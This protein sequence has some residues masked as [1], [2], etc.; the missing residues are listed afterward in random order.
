MPPPS[1]STAV[2]D[3]VAIADASPVTAPPAESVALIRL[4]VNV[5]GLALSTLAVIAVVV[6][7]ELAQAFFVSLLLGILAAYTLNP[8]IAY[9]ERL[10]IPRLAGTVLVMVSVIG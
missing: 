9:L 2:P 10:R 6:A 1:A 8:L 4:P 5:R 7:L 3:P